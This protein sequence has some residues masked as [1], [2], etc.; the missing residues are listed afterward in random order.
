MKLVECVPNFSEGK[1][2]KILDAIANEI[3]SVAGVK[4][5]DID[6]GAATNRT[7]FTM[8]GP[9]DEV[10][11]AAFLAIKKAAELIDM[12][13]HKGAHPRFG[14]TDVCPFVPISGMTMEDCVKL[15]KRLGKRVG[16]EL[17][18]PVYLYD[19]AAQTPQRASLADVRSGEYEGLP[20]KLKQPE[21]K[22]DFGPAQFNPKTGVTAIGARQ[23]LIAYNVNLNTTSTKLAKHIALSIREKGRVKRDKDGNKV[24]DENGDA[25]YTPGLFKHCRATGWL[26]PE[27]NCAQITINLTDFAVSSMHE[28]FDACCEL[29][30]KEGVRVTGSE[31]VGLVP[32]KA[33][34]DAGLHYLKKQKQSRGVT[35]DHLIQTAIRSLGLNDVSTFD[36]ERKIVENNFKQPT[37]LAS[38][39]LKA[40]AEELSSNSPAP[41]G[42]SVAALAGGLSAALSSMVA[43]LTYDKKGYTELNPEMDE[44][45]QKAQIN[46]REQI[47]AIDTD[48]QAFNKVMDC[49]S[50][51]KKTEAE[52]KSRTQAIEEATK[53]ATLIP[54]S[55]LE[56]SITALKC[57]QTLAEKGSANSASDAGVAGLMGYSAAMGAYYNVLINLSGISDKKWTAKIEKDADN[58]AKK[59]K[60]LATTIEKTMIAKLKP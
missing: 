41:G 44:I 23:F 8:A 32:K 52:K 13:K 14:A 53:Q 47:A 19:Q 56:K 24:V 57:A 10:V 6:P 3:K 42:G 35:E 60:E 38:M 9:P 36:P 49:F 22:P 1:D 27:Y 58:L 46:L 55:V 50:L 45:G 54:F 34:I 59:A 21:W 29:A 5:L 7:V 30:Q 48:T 37:P 43:I 25:V 40:F 20:E 12:S 17:K 2:K 31:I 16:E 11:E 18:I 4:L 15:A 28:V 51:P 26:I 39:S 33:M